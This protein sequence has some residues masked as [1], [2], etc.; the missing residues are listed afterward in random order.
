MLC[1]VLRS[2]H[3]HP[4]T[5]RFVLLVSGLGLGGGGSDSLLGTQWLV[6]VVTGQLGDEGKS[7]ELLTCPGLSLKGMSE[8]QHPEQ[9]FCQ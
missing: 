4:D 8:P 7:A 3:P 6:E 5:D 2:L 1:L 9:R